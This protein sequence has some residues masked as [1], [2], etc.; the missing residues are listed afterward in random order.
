MFV[1]SHQHQPP[2][3]PPIVVV[4][5]TYWKLPGRKSLTY[6]SVAVFVPLFAASIVIASSFP[7]VAFGLACW[8][9]ETSA[10]TF[11]LARPACSS[12]APVRNT[13]GGPLKGLPPALGLSMDAW[14]L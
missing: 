6:A 8:I 2:G 3:R 1:P 11:G 13:I 9:T 10:G 12:P 7:T 14:P 4:Q 5:S